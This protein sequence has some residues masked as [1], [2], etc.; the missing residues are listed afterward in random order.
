MYRY[1]RLALVTHPH[2]D[3]VM[4]KDRATKLKTFSEISEAFEVLSDGRL[5]PLTIERL[6][7]RF[8]NLGEE[9]LKRDQRSG[10]GG[11]CP[12]YSELIGGYRFKNNAL[13]IF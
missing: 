9:G 5:R 11:E 10:T 3:T 12:F 7:A 2:R 6:R 13:D 1:R 4:L 8:D